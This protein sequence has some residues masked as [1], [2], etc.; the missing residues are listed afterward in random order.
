[1]RNA[2]ILLLLSYVTLFGGSNAATSPSEFVRYG[3][4]HPVLRGYGGLSYAAPPVKPTQHADVGIVKIVQVPPRQLSGYVSTVETKPLPLEARCKELYLNTEKNLLSYISGME[5]LT[6]S[7]QE[8]DEAVQELR[9][10]SKSCVIG[11]PAVSSTPLPVST[12]QPTNIETS[13]LTNLP[14]TGTPQLPQ[15]TVSP[16]VVSTE[17]FTDPPIVITRSRRDMSTDIV[18]F[19]MPSTSGAVVDLPDHVSEDLARASNDLKALRRDLNNTAE[20]LKQTN[21]TVHSVLLRALQAY[22]VSIERRVD[23]QRLLYAQTR[24]T[25]LKTKI[26]VIKEKVA[27][28]LDKLKTVAPQFKRQF[29]NINREDLGSSPNSAMSSP[30]G[31]IVINNTPTTTIIPAITSSP[32]NIVSTRPGPL[33]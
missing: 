1:M 18:H 16:S 28:L 29:G 14:T 19:G 30:T 5:A 25:A 32:L 10:T 27:S 23:H 4:H 33:S 20:W 9:P 11:Q 7:I 15:T 12:I 3:P 6:G 8:L 24:G 22:V 17:S 26:A 21:H 13:T 2:L 31:T